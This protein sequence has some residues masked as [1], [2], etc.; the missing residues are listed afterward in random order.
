MT[1]NGGTAPHDIGAEQATLG[2][3][4]VLGERAID[5]LIIAQPI[6]FYRQAHQTIAQV[7]IDMAAAHIPIDPQTVLRGLMSRG[8]VGQVGGAPYL[9]D[10]TQR[11][12]V[13]ENADY[14]AR[15]VRATYSQRVAIEALDQGLDRFSTL[16]DPDLGPQLLAEVQ[17]KLTTA[18]EAA[19]IA[20]V[21]ESP[22][23]LD[24]LAVPTEYDWQ[25]EGLLE[26]KD[27]LILTGH[28][29]HGKS[30]YLRELACCFAGGLHPHDPHLIDPNRVLVVDVENTERQ[31]SRQYRWVVD[32]VTRMITAR[33]GQPDWGNLRIEHRTD[34]LKL[35]TAEG[36][37]WLDKTIAAN[38]P[39]MLVIG[40]LYKLYSGTSVN[41]ETAA[42]DL[43]GY[44]DELR[45]KHDMTLL[46]EA[47]AGHA[48]NS[49]GDRAVR[50]R[51]SSLFLGWPEFGLGL[52]R[53]KDD[54]EGEHPNVLDVVRWRPSR[55]MRSWPFRLRRGGAGSLPWVEDMT[56]S[57]VAGVA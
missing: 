41:E 16:T 23:V 34:G 48:L 2:C 51:G 57:T 17:A 13:P 53:A 18:A 49:Q 43:A 15:I 26:R 32:V 54:T 29:G 6:M 42:A 22:T 31:N 37:L 35:T 20:P 28:E 56:M 50:P 12:W 33:G 36:R 47:H 8:T 46:I 38:R 9:F 11:A 55:E 7:M 25:V 52:A 10:L 3:V 14:Y 40:P 39:D 24:V 45:T 30:T 19:V 4:L 27:R 21:T 44:F 1:D 5:A